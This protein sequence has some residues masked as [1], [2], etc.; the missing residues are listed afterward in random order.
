MGRTR[1][2]Y[3]N[4]PEGMYRR[5]QKSGKVYYYMRQADRKEVALGSDYILALKKYSEAKVNTRVEA[6]V[7]FKAVAER[8]QREVIPLKGMATQKTNLAHL[9]HLVE[10]F[11]N[12]TPAPLE[13]ITPQIVY[14]YMDWRKGSPVVANKEKTLLHHIWKHAVRWGYTSKPNPCEQ[15]ESFKESG[16]DY[17]IEDAEYELALKYADAPTRD[18]LEMMYLTGQRP[19]DALK[20][21]EGDIKGNELHITQNKTGKKLRMEIKGALKELIDRIMERKANHKVRSLYLICNNEGHKLTLIAL[22]KRWWTLREKHPEITF[23]LRDLRA[24]AATDKAES[25]DPYTAQKQLGHEDI[26]MT[27]HYIRNRKGDKVE[28]TK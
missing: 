14:K 3:L 10:F 1:T 23:Q 17:Y 22:T 24:K 4:L 7:T 11:T 2:K 28:P 21:Q 6:H 9:K 8:Y 27:K 16:R 20:M 26:S 5:T 25:H 19:A 18:A 15:V 13:A 12:P